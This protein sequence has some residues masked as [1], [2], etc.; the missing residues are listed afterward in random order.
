MQARIAASINTGKLVQALG[1]H[2]QSWQQAPPPL[3]EG[4]AFSKALIKEVPHVTMQ[5]QTHTHTHTHPKISHKYNANSL[6]SSNILSVENGSICYRCQGNDD[7][8]A[9]RPSVATLVNT[10]T[11]SQSIHA[12][13]DIERGCGKLYLLTNKATRR[14]Q[15]ERVQ[16]SSHTTL[17]RDDTLQN[18]LG[19][20]IAISRCHG[21]GK[22]Q[23]GTPTKTLRL[24]NRFWG[25][26]RQMYQRNSGMLDQ[27]QVQPT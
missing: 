2:Q 9:P 24:Y 3:E 1:K 8:I 14:D 26:F 11:A 25:Y 12:F 4:L 5:P 10:H 22:G 13:P 6:H 19:P 20:E 21:N 7:I 15:N 16:L 17:Y 23:L 18:N 27:E